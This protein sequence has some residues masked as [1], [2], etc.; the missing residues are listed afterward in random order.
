MK[1]SKVDKFGRVLIP[2]N[3]R[4]KLG[5]DD[6]VDI[7]LRGDE[8]VIKAR[9][10]LCKICA[11]EIDTGLPIPLCREC[12]LDAKRYADELEPDGV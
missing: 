5:L 8:I 7:S 6:A 9:D 3:Y 11:A 12:I 1:D 2:V 10:T 4:R